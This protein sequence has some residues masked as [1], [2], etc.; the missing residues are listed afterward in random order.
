MD[1]KTNVVTCSIC[2]H[3]MA[4]P[5]GFEGKA[6][7]CSKCGTSLQTGEDVLNL[8]LDFDLGSPVTPKAAA[9]AQP[10]SHSESR[11]PLKKALIKASVHAL[12]GLLLGM[13]ALGIILGILAVVTSPSNTHLATSFRT[14]FNGG[15]SFGMLGGFMV[16]AIVSLMYSLDPSI[17]KG[18]AIGASI[19]LIA[20]LVQYAIE[21]TFLATSDTT[22]LLNG[23]IGTFGG[24]TLAALTVWYRQYRESR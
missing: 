2:G 24:A 19:G 4:I 7:R 23:L 11:V 18:A 20:S 14:A 16:G 13:V 10:Q 22:A 9:P 1:T 17:P 12:L 6:G 15:V 3:R 5:P 8:K 21:N